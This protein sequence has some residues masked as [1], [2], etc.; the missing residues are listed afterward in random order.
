MLFFLSEPWSLCSV[1][2]KTEDE[3]DEKM[4]DSE[5]DG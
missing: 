3:K 2:I 5:N 4:Y 1:Q